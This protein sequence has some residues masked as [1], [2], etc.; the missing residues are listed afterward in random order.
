MLQLV[1]Y[2]IACNYQ[3]INLH[4][5]LAD[6]GSIPYLSQNNLNSSHWPDS[7]QMWIGCTPPCIHNTL[8]QEL[9]HLFMSVPV[10]SLLQ[11][12]HDISQLII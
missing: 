5:N 11:D 4:T 3:C 10:N 9:R 6:I 1:L 7:A 12:P 8:T 2:V